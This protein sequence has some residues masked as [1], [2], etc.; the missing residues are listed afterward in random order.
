MSVH[1]ILSARAPAAAGVSQVSYLFKGGTWRIHSVSLQNEAVVAAE[2]GMIKV[3]FGTSVYDPS[4]T[5]HP[6]Q[7]GTTRA[8]A[9]MIWDDGFTFTGEFLVVGEIDHVLA[10]V[11]ELT[12]IAWKVKEN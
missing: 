4:R 9:P 7:I 2:P 8:G 3:Q 12:V 1:G 10:V 6:L 11:H 5:W